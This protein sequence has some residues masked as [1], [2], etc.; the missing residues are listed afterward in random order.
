MRAPRV[1]R[2][3]RMCGEVWGGERAP[4]CPRPLPDS[5]PSAPQLCLFHPKGKGGGGGSALPRSEG[6]GWLVSSQRRPEASI[7]GNPGTPQAG[8]Q[9]QGARTA[10]FRHLRK[11]LGGGGACFHRGGCWVIPAVPDFHRGPGLRWLPGCVSRLYELPGQGSP[12]QRA[13]R[14]SAVG[15]ARALRTCAPGGCN[16]PSWG[17][18]PFSRSWRNWDCLAR[19]ALSPRTVLSRDKRHLGALRRVSPEPQAAVPSWDCAW[20]LER[21]IQERGVGGG[22]SSLQAVHVA[23][24]PPLPRSTG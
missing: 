12:G 14:G 5:P 18:Y 22:P 2:M 10:A 20:P 11:C 23:P 6:P 13:R 15:G 21:G 16:L 4:G 17:C 9:A 19:V 1:P 3:E 8:S 7:P 24:D